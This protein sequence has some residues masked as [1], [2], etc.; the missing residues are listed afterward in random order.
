MCI[1]TAYF[2][3][4]CVNRNFLVRIPQHVSQT[5]YLVNFCIFCSLI[6]ALSNGTCFML[7]SGGEL[8]CAKLNSNPLARGTIEVFVNS[9]FPTESGKTLRLEALDIDS[10][11]TGLKTTGKLGAYSFLFVGK[12]L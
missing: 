7:L 4:A 5:L 11:L 12:R 9:G 2:A 6:P 1:V 10:R 3:N 8:K